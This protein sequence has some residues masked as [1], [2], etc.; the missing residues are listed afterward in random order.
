MIRSAHLNPGLPMISFMRHIAR[1]KGRASNR[2][3]TPRS[4]L[5]RSKS[6]APS[7]Y[8]RSV[9]WTALR[10]PA[11]A[12]HHAL[13]AQCPS[14]PAQ[15]D[16]LALVDWRS[17]YPML[18]CVVGGF[19]TGRTQPAPPDSC[20]AGT[21]GSGTEAARTALSGDSTFVT[22]ET[23]ASTGS[24][25]KDKMDTSGF[26]DLKKPSPSLTRAPHHLFPTFHAPIPIDVR[27][28]EGRYHYEP[29]ALH[30]MHGPVGLAGSPVISD[31][32]LIRLS[33]AAAAMATGEASP[34]GPPPH[35]YAVSH[36]HMEHYL[37]SV[38]ASPSLSMIS[39]ARGLSPA[40][41]AHEQLKERGLL[42]L[43]PRGPARW[44]TTT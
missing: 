11:P 37:R 15:H 9:L 31:I 44:S 40:D 36:H 38:H 22:M 7:G 1:F 4:T 42:G 5:S 16:A 43:P 35:P 33:P 41:L 29:H 8:E 27:H 26:G 12:T 6:L 23:S 14:L 19:K 28:H 13:E 20:G 30:A 32:S 21:R 25:R 34:F 39:A 24:E 2:S 3:T 17:Y 10:G 18:L